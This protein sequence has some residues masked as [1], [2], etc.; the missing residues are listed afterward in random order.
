MTDAGRAATRPSIGKLPAFDHDAAEAYN[1][2]YLHGL[3]D[4]L[5]WRPE[6][7]GMLWIALSAGNWPANSEAVG[8]G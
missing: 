2:I 8:D 1:A 5:N 4:R 7:S 6:K 3:K